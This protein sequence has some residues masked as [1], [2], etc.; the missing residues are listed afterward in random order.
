MSCK[1]RPIPFFSPS[2]GSVGFFRPNRVADVVFMDVAETVKVPQMAESISE[3]T[4]RTWNKQV[5]DSV[6]ADEEVVTIETDKVRP[7]HSCSL[8]SRIDCQTRLMFQSTHRSPERSLNF[9]PMKKTPSLLVK[10]YL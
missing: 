9:W 6:A 10:I 7:V 2:T 1:T 4:L 5:G 8:K 3:G